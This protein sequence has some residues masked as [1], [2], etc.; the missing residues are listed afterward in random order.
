[1]KE[2]VHGV[3]AYLKVK[4]PATSKRSIFKTTEFWLYKHF[5]YSTNTD[6]ATFKLVSEIRNFPNF[7]QS[8]YW[9]IIAETVANKSMGWVMM[10]KQLLESFWGNILS[11]FWLL[12]WKDRLCRVAPYSIFIPLWLYVQIMQVFLLVRPFMFF[13]S[14]QYLP[15]KELRF[16]SLAAPVSRVWLK[17]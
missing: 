6:S 11:T 12:L 8:S 13:G 4:K 10:D 5:Y 9:F 17:S 14:Q 2:W 16:Y 15:W 3:T 1:M 7:T